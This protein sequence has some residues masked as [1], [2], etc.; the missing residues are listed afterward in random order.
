MK[1]GKIKDWGIGLPQWGPRVGTVW[2]NKKVVAS[3]DCVGLRL[4]HE[5][6]ILM[7]RVQEVRTLCVRAVP[8]CTEYG[9]HGRDWGEN[10]LSQNPR[11]SLRQTTELEED[12][13]QRVVCPGHY[14]RYQL[15]LWVFF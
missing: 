10:S 6:D 12:K 15:P 4:Y 14:D 9:S 11:S 2:G 13:R 5:S 3:V 8:G 7:Y 1:G